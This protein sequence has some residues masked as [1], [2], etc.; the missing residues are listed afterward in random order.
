[1]RRYAFAR[2][3]ALAGVFAVGA[4]GI[5]G[6]YAGEQHVKSTSLIVTGMAPAEGKDARLTYFEL[7][8][9]W[10]GSE[11]KHFHDVWL[12]ILEGHIVVETQ[13]VPPQTFGPGKMFHEEPNIVMKIRNMSK[14]EPVKFVGFEVGEKGHPRVSPVVE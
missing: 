2:N 7:P 11:H 1:M 10:V 12:L 14:S 9:G 4:L 3:L 13:G 6:L 8:P 5:Q